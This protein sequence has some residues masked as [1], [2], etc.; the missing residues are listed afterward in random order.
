MKRSDA[1]K[2]HHT[3]LVI[4]KTYRLRSSKGEGDVQLLEDKGVE[5]WLVMII[6]GQFTVF[7]KKYRA[8][9]TFLVPPTWDGW[10][11]LQA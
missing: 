3:N 8:G 5:G 7:E 4:D 1:T 2:I 9:E 11:E 6:R 10:Y